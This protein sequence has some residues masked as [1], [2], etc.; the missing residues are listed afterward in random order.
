MFEPL[1]GSSNN[2]YNGYNG[3]NGYN[4]YNGYNCYNIQR[5]IITI[6][7]TGYNI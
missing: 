7:I 4:G 1:L 6:I 2:G 3:H 5:N